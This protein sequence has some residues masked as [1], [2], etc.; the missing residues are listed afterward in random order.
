MVQKIIKVGNSAAV[1]I[2]KSFM[3]EAGWKIGD[4]V[5]VKG[6][7]KKRALLIQ[8]ELM[9]WLDEFTEKHKDFIKEL[10]KV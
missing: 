8:T 4:E 10:A 1:T 2:P 3:K 9:Q 5:V 7:S 6:N